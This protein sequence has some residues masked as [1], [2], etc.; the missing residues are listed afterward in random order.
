MG[1]K[2]MGFFGAVPWK[3]AASVIPLLVETVFKVKNSGGLD[4]EQKEIDELKAQ[5]KTLDSEIGSLYKGVRLIVAGLCIVF[6]IAV[7]ALIVGIVA[8][9]KT[10]CM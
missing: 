10:Q 2:C 8:L 7:A 4:K 1:G 9:S 3:A 6:V 5:V